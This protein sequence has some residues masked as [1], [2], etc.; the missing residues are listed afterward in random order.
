MRG[1]QI[2]MPDSLTALSISPFVLRDQVLGLF[3]GMT[4]NKSLSVSNEV[5]EYLNYS[6]TIS[7]PIKQRALIPYLNTFDTVLAKL[8][9]SFLVLHSLL[10]LIV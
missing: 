5:D 1:L 7:L 10:F 9:H 3:Q 2:P 4:D 6:I 8:L